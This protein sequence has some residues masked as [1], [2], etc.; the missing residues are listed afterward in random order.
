MR[1]I[2]IS[3]V[4]FIAV[5]AISV[6]MHDPDEMPQFSISSQANPEIE[7]PFVEE[8]A[9]GKQ[10]DLAALPQDSISETTPEATDQN[11]DAST[12]SLQEGPAPQPAGGD[13][14]SG[15]KI[16]ST[17]VSATIS[18]GANQTVALATESGVT[19]Q[20]PP[21]EADKK[22][23]G[24]LAKSAERRRNKNKVA[25][26]VHI[27]N[28]QSLTATE[29]RAMYMDRLTQWKDGSK[30]M[31]YNLPLGDK[32]REKFSQRILNMSALQADA[33]EAVRRENNVARNPVRVKAKNIVVSYVERHPNAIA[34]VPLS[35]V[36][37]RSK[38]K[39]VMTLP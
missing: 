13:I 18:P 38:V 23:L 10:V 31:L 27:E 39:V 26:I 7:N 25:V 19:E 1:V 34:Y 2:W 32:H 11:S 35:M 15:N 29:I 22:P 28:D 37:D 30:V 36:R 24:L 16:E 6:G 20:Q 3:L 14:G 33:E 21:S 8:E 17:D 5:F 4:I 9:A 12:Q